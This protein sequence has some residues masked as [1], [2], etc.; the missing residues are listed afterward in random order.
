MLVCMTLLFNSCKK[1]DE[2]PFTS[3]FRSKLDGV[4]F[5]C[6]SGINIISTGL[7]PGVLE[8]TGSWYQGNI[9]IKILSGVSSI[10]IGTYDIEHAT[11]LISCQVTINNYTYGAYCGFI[12]DPGPHGKGKVNILEIT[13]DMVKGT[14]EFTTRDSIPKNVT[15]GA[16]SIKRH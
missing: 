15:D 4:P 10:A 16:F 9:D 12:A 1:S 2:T 5:E 8:I 13:P 7:V 6:N 3:Y 14:F 11:E